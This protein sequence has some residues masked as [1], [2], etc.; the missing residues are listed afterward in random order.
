MYNQ[1]LLKLNVV[2]L[3]IMGVQVQ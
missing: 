3:K 1:L 2:I